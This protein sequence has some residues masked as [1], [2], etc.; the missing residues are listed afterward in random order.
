MNT[1]TLIRKIRSMAMDGSYKEKSQEEI[2][3]DENSKW[4]EFPWNEVADCVN[5][6]LIIRKH[7]Y[8]EKQ[9][10][11]VSD[12]VERLFELIYDETT[13]ENIIY[14]MDKLL[15]MFEVLPETDYTCAK[16]EEANFMKAYW[17]H[18]RHETVVVLGDSH[19]NFF[20]GA[21]LLS[22]IPI[23]HDVNTCPIMEEQ[24]FTPLH[25]GPCLAY[26]VDN[27]NAS[28]NSM[29]KTEWLCGNFIVPGSRIICSFGEIDI[30]VHVL[31]QAELRKISV[32][33]VVD[34]I[35][36]HYYTLLTKLKDRGYEVWCWGPIATQQDSNEQD[37]LFPHYGS[38][39]ERNKASE[40]FN[41][42][43]KSWCDANGVGFM[44]IFKAMIDENYMTKVE[45]L[46]ADGCHLGQRARELAEPEWRKLFGAID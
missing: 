39:R 2:L 34:D 25:L 43:L 32:E 21:E 13:D 6:E 18:Q 35:L 5:S 23:G 7:L 15:A 44:S 3:T 19:V 12:K 33:N 29:E 4:E 45:Y 11:D 46:S 22:F 27:P 28:Y 42:A 14:A 37:E 20:S 36:E 9:F 17:H 24:R 30:R 26:N 1:I 8:P 41:D 38:E 16:H 31:K 40:Y 10:K